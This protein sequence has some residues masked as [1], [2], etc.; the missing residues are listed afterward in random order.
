MLLKR[1]LVDA[2][3]KTLIRECETNKSSTN[4]QTLPIELYDLSK[5]AHT[6]IPLKITSFY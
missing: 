5:S 3:V 2:L 4:Q 1:S 6:F